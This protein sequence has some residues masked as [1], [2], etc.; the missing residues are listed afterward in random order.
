MPKKKERVQYGAPPQADLGCTDGRHGTRWYLEQL[1]R[2]EAA[3]PQEAALG[4]GG[5]GA[6][7][8]VEDV[9][10]RERRLELEQLVVV[11]HAL[12]DDEAQV[13]IQKVR[14]QPAA[15]LRQ[16]LAVVVQPPC[17]LHVEH[18]GACMHGMGT[19]KKRS[20]WSVGMAAHVFLRQTRPAGRLAGHLGNRAVA[21]C[22]AARL[23]SSKLWSS[24]TMKKKESGRTVLHYQSSCPRRRCTPQRTGPGPRQFP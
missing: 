18:G 24:G 1:G 12:L 21:C 14:L 17:V 20:Y 13:A 16:A 6:G 15:K 23:K 11:L 19:V 5:P 10:A 4:G 2:A 8:E 9:G 22:M 3:H 7:E